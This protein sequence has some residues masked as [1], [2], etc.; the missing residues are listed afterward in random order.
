MFNPPLP[1]KPE[2]LAFYP[3]PPVLSSTLLHSMLG[4]GNECRVTEHT[5]TSYTIFPMGRTSVLLILF[6][7]SG[8]S[9]AP[10]IGEVFNVNHGAQVTVSS[11]TAI[12]TRVLEKQ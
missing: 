7:S 6:E 9:M 10:D 11:C 4:S 1:L 3:K 5:V 8:C 12:G 2:P